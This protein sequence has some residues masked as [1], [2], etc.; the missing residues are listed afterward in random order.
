[1]IQG[2]LDCLCRCYHLCSYFTRHCV[3]WQT[4][5]HGLTGCRVSKRTAWKM[6]KGVCV[7]WRLWWQGDIFHSAGNVLCVSEWVKEELLT[8]IWLKIDK[9]NSCVVGIPTCI[10][11]SVLMCSCLWTTP[12]G[13]TWFCNNLV[14]R[15]LRIVTL[16]SASLLGKTHHMLS[17]QIHIKH[18]LQSNYHID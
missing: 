4:D 14:G 3:I 8:G 1:M 15:Q 2:I 13:F 12:S 7:W 9:N 10:L 11:T 18:K 5:V 6:E 16:P 17:D